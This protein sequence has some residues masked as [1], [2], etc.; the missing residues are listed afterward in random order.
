MRSFLISTAL[1]CAAA[2]AAPA[3]AQYNPQNGGY[4]YRG[5]QNVE[6]QL[7]QLRQ[8]VERSEDRDRLSN[9]ERY[10][11]LRQI[12]TIDRLYDRYRRNG[13]TQWEASDI[14]NRIQNVRQRFRWER[15]EDRY[16]DRRDRYDDRRDRRNDDR[17][18]RDDY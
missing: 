7:H 15:Q 18:G 16:D 3:S 17:R 1:I 10:Q 6:R 4:D 9:R 8:R 13:L 2:V 12:E 11:L 5:G 14:Q